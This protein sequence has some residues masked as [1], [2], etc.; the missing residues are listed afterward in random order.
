MEVLFLSKSI[1]LAVLQYRKK[2]PDFSVLIIII[3]WKFYKPSEKSIWQC[4]RML[5]LCYTD[6]ICAPSRSPAEA[7]PGVHQLQA[8]ANQIAALPWETGSHDPPWPITGSPGNHSCVADIRR[9]PSFC[10]CKQENTMLLLC[11]HHVAMINVF[12]LYACFKSNNS[13]FYL[14]KLHAS[15]LLSECEG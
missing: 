1:S 7:P 3:A 10:L 2:V 5:Y 14:L 12:M 4:L 6:R 13:Y 15:L 9:L 8:S 11:H